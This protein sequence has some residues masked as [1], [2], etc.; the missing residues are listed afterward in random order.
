M[1]ANS[2]ISAYNVFI[3]LLTCILSLSSIHYTYQES[4][5]LVKNIDI[6]E[7]SFEL[8]HEFKHN[9]GILKDEKLKF[10]NFQFC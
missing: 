7:P 5:S 4:T 6:I 9:I 8:K 2:F 1:F 3:Y 10:G